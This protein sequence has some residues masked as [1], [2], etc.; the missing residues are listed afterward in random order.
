M[1]IRTPRPAKVLKQILSRGS[2]I[3]LTTTVML[4]LGCWGKMPQLGGRLIIAAYDFG[5]IYT[6][7]ASRR[8]V[9]TLVKRGLWAAR[10]SPDGS[11]YALR[12]INP[13][14]GLRDALNGPECDAVVK[15]EGSDSI[16]K[17]LFTQPGWF[18]S[19][20]AVA[21]MQLVVL[22]RRSQNVGI[23]KLVWLSFKGEV[24]RELLLP[25][26]ARKIAAL[27]GREGLLLSQTRYT[28][29]P[30]IHLIERN[31]RIE[32]LGPGSYAIPLSEGVYMYED[33]A[34]PP[35]IHKRFLDS[36]KDVLIRCDVR[37]IG[38]A[39][40]LGEYLI[41]SRPTAIGM[42]EYT[43]L[44]FYN[45]E[46]DYLIPLTRLGKDEPITVSWLPQ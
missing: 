35:C 37:L 2:V 5:T 44:M 46:N 12:Q 27:P 20:L 24:E 38:V 36:R 28:Q 40:S 8:Q 33:N 43:E 23:E 1:S 45:L 9:S 3:V 32:D 10:G 4:M 41:V 13:A 42:A 16:S 19:D 39:G 11:I 29:D 15:I 18:L 26:F 22:M 34:M 21:D 17:P 6:W 31:N 25:L 30:R 7:T 14:S